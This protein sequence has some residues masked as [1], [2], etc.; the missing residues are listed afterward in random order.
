MA[1]HYKK[2]PTNDVDVVIGMDFKTSF[3]YES[4]MEIR[5]KYRS[6]YKYSDFDA[7]KEIVHDI[8]K[9]Q[10]GRFCRI[11]NFFVIMLCYLMF[12]LTLPISGCF[13]IKILTNDNAAIEV[14]ADVYYRIYDAI[15][16]ISRIKDLDMSTRILSQTILQTYLVKQIL[17]DIESNKHMISQILLVCQ[18]QNLLNMV[19]PALFPAGS[20]APMIT[21]PETSSSPG[22]LV[23]MQPQHLE[24]TS[25]SSILTPV[26]SEQGSAVV[27]V[28]RNL[29]G[30]SN[31]A[32]GN[33]PKSTMTLNT[34]Q[35][36]IEAVRPHLG[37]NMVKEFDT[38]YKF[39]VSG[40]GGGTFYLDLKNE[41]GSAD[42]GDPPGGDPDVTLTLT[43]DILRKIL[44]GESS[45]FSAYMT[46]ELVIEGNVH[47]ASHLAKLIDY[48]G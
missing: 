45:A 47:A 8:D 36:V 15:L 25:S 13:C 34:P 21:L 9:L 20:N 10:N 16:S 41:G 3:Q 44:R 28:D 26:M 1:T 11:W 32:D 42:E 30:S 46:G 6:I 14:G 29:L 5:K 18:A 33:K 39:I 4:D 48:I 22:Q 17:A 24:Q 19:T 23:Q 27:E 2:L 12:F 40:N 31:V 7:D 35:D 37:P 38:L 43:M